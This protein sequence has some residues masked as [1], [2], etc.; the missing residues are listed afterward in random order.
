MRSTL[1]DNL[2]KLPVGQLHSL[3]FVLVFFILFIVYLMT[4]LIDLVYPNSFSEWMTSIN[5][6]TLFSSYVKI[7]YIGFVLPLVISTILLSL[8]FVS[9]KVNL[10]RKY[11]NLLIL[12]LIFDTLFSSFIFEPRIITSYGGGPNLPA[13]IGALLY[14]AYLAWSDSL[15][16]G[17]YLSYVLGFIIGAISDIESIRH[18]TKTSTFGGG[19]FL[20]VDFVFPLIML[21]SFWLSR[22]MVIRQRSTRKN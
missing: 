22:K 20:D 6:P 16:G 13:M 5:T 19:G 10:N 17:Y 2:K 4:G 1:R 3:F 9:G 11:T 21:I 8:Y 12:F 7:N 14:V 15:R 18:L